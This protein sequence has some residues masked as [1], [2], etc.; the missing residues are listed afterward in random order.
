M[1]CL[2]PNCCQITQDKKNR[3][4]TAYYSWLHNRPLFF[5]FDPFC[6]HPTSNFF[7]QFIQLRKKRRINARSNPYSQHTHTHWLAILLNVIFLWHIFHKPFIKYIHRRFLPL[8]NI[9]CPFCNFPF[10]WCAS[11][12]VAYIHNSHPWAVVWPV[13]RLCFRR[14]Y[15]YFYFIIIFSLTYHDRGCATRVYYT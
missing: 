12:N 6:S 4:G 9:C 2:T 8:N 3:C 5:K 15:G 13:V 11:C 14:M 7:F 10:F 1:S